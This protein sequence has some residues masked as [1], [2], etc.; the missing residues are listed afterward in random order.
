MSA[1]T[2]RQSQ[3]RDTQGRFAVTGSFDG[4]ARQSIPAR[5]SPE[6]EHGQLV[7]HLASLSRTFRG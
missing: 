7:G 3:E 2:G 1:L 4:G 6:R 5:G